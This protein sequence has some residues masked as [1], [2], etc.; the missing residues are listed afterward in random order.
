MVFRHPMSMPLGGRLDSVTIADV[1]DRSRE[2][3]GESSRDRALICCCGHG[4]A[5]LRNSV[6][7]DW[8]AK[9]LGRAVFDFKTDKWSRCCENS[10]NG[11]HLWRYVR[12]GYRR[13]RH[14]APSATVRGRT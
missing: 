10:E 4:G 2:V 6:R 12:D 5:S 1:D 7:F 8:G 9:A 3:V 13:F 11:A 14:P